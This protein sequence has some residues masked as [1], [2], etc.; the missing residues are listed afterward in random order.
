MTIEHLD[1]QFGEANY[2]K[3]EKRIEEKEKQEKDKWKNLIE[4]IKT[5]CPT[6]LLDLINSLSNS[7]IRKQ[8]KQ[9]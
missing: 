7:S 3:E 2:Q 5:F 6:F 8:Q 1:W 4:Q 9:S